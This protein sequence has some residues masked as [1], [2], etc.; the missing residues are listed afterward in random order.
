M[1]RRFRAL[2]LAVAW[3]AALGSLAWGGAPAISSV[4]VIMANSQM[5]INGTGFSP[6]T[7]APTVS[8]AGTNLTVATVTNT[9]SQQESVKAAD[10]RH[11]PMGA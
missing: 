8:L 5:T 3:G 11:F 2:I 4:A 9:G 1:F 10:F 7:A 6:G